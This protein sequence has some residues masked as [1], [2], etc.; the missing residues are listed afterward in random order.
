MNKDQILSDLSD[1][2]EQGDLQ[3]LL[4][5]NLPQYLLDALCELSDLIGGNLYCDDADVF[6]IYVTWFLYGRKLDVIPNSIMSK[7]FQILSVALKAEKARR[8]GIIKMKDWPLPT[9]DDLFNEK[10]IDFYF[11]KNHLDTKSKQNPLGII[12]DPFLNEN[13]RLPNM[14]DSFAN[15]MKEYFRTIQ[16]HNDGLSDSDLIYVSVYFAID[17]LLEYRDNA[18][19]MVPVSII[20]DTKSQVLGALNNI[21]E[22]PDERQYTDKIQELIDRKIWEPN[23]EFETRDFLSRIRNY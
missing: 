1:L 8:E 14:V 17:I 12:D 15:D 3:S 2:K 7:K 18:Q 4:P 20:K 23:I 11:Y 10:S 13:H 5:Q 22:I 9:I 19:N 21:F 6:H 16:D